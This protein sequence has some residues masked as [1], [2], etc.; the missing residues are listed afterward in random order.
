MSDYIQERRNATTSEDF[1]NEI[2]PEDESPRDLAAEA[3]AAVLRK[4]MSRRRHGVTDT[5]TDDALRRLM[6][7]SFRNFIALVF[8]MRP[9]L[10][11]DVPQ[12][13]L[14]Q[15]LGCTRAALS[16]LC[17]KWSLKLGGMKTGG[18]KSIEAR[19]SYRVAA[20]GRR[21]KGQPHRKPKHVGESLSNDAF[22]ERT[23]RLIAEAVSAFNAGDPWTMHQ[24]HALRRAG[25][26]NDADELTEAGRE[27]LGAALL[28]KGDS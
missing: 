23:A 22:A 21:K 11:P 17:V 18:M 24:R 5:T 6:E 4:V 27:L 10:L 8:V 15:A 19:D 26:V 25:L 3:L 2:E 13:R 16:R 1:Y 7:E 12:W 14:A 28:E 9:D 20:T